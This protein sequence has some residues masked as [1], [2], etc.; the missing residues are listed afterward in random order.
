MGAVHFETVYQIIGEVRNVTVRIS[1][2]DNYYTV[3]SVDEN[4]TELSKTNQSVWIDLS[5]INLMIMIDGGTS[6]HPLQQST[7]SK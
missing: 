6:D 4:I 3:V 2:T 5:V 1:A 7:V